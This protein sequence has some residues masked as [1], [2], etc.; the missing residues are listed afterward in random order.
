MSTSPFGS[1]AFML[2]GRD[3]L[4]DLEIQAAQAETV[5][6]TAPGGEVELRGVSYRGRCV[7]RRAHVPILNVRYDGDACGPYR[8]WQNEEGRFRAQGAAVAPGF[9]LCTGKAKTIMRAAHPSSC[10]A[11]R[12]RNARRRS[13]AACSPAEDDHALSSRSARKSHTGPSEYR[14]WGP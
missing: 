13:C 12:R 7:L 10:S 5:E 4:V 11:T 1:L 2:L 9:R 8:D 3:Y 6:F 14:T